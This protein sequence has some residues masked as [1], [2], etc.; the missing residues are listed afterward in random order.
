MRSSMVE[1]VAVRQN[2]ERSGWRKTVVG[3][4]VAAIV[5]AMTQ[6]DAR[7]KSTALTFA[8]T[9]VPIAIGSTFL[10]LAHIIPNLIPS[11]HPAFGNITAKSSKAKY[12]ILSAM[13]HTTKRVVLAFRLAGEPGRR[14]LDG[15]FRRIADLRLDWQLQFVR[16][17][18]DFN[19]EFVASFPERGIDGVVFSLPSARD[20][21]EALARLDIP[22]VALDIF[23]ESIMHDRRKN[24]IYIASSCDD[25]GR[26]A[27]RHFLSQGLYRSYAFIPDLAGAAWSRLRGE[28]FADEMARNGFK[29]AMYKT[30]G[31]G[32]DLPKLR[33]WIEKLP[34]PAG[35]FAAFD[36]RAVQVLEAC[37]DAGLDV[38]QQ[39]AVIG[40][41]NDEIICPNTTPPLTSVQPDHT[42]IGSLAA[43]KLQEMMDGRSL[44]RPERIMVGVK[45]IAI[46]GSTCPVTQSG[47]LVQ[48]ALAFIAA[49]YAEPIRSRDVVRELKCSRRL[50]DLRFTELQGES[51][52]KAILHTRLE[53]VRKMLTATNDT[54]EN[55]ATAC[56]FPKVDR[57]RA[58]FMGRY[59][60]SPSEY[61]SAKTDWR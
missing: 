37:R 10:S 9:V 43:E 44:S 1:F 56:G 34:R 7:Q 59:G 16:I 15:F 24:L 3:S 23:D 21:A 26:T 31:K 12:G 18:E 49:H 27:A 32:Y 22:T 39:I 20:G 28:A 54:I 48:R 55:I 47:K 13:N 5:G 2:D 11:Q 17:R 30:R 50:A 51:I 41:D 6:K 33:V 42:L 19:A 57:M 52:G 29:V 40:V 14:K 36:D 4:L 25:I 46:R 38:P 61:R 53:A 58:A 60:V 8:Q 45:R 35:V